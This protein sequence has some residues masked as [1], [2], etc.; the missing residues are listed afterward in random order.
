MP[1][2]KRDHFRKNLERWKNLPEEARAA[3]RSTEQ[4]RRRRLHG[5]AEQALANSKLQLDEPQRKAY[6]KRYIE[7]RRKIEKTLHEEMAA[8]RKPLLEELNQRLQ[9]EFS[10]GAA[11][12]AGSVPSP[13]SAPGEQTPS[14]Q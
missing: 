1:P 5:E 7:E 12:G 14:D 6:R 11:A 10:S 13:P 9:K 8:K 2:E 3:L 4:Q